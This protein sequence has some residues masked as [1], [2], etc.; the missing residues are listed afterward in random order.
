VRSDGFKNL[1]VRRRG[2][3]SR[4]S[5]REAVSE[6]RKIKARRH[7]TMLRIAG[8]TMRPQ[9]GLILRDAADAAPQY[10]G[11]EPL[12]AQQDKAASQTARPH[13]AILFNNIIGQSEQCR[14]NIQA[15]G[16]GRLKINHKLEFGRLFDRQISGL[17]TP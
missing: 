17:G 9:R 14:R 12:A 8:R 5:E 7:R 6:R 13:I 16:R 4:P 1:M 3:P 11:I 10:E 2:R 15:E